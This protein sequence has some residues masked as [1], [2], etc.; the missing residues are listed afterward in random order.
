MKRIFA[1]AVAIFTV[2][3]VPTACGESSDEDASTAGT[4]AA[5]T[6]V[7]PDAAPLRSPVKTAPAAT[8]AGGPLDS[9]D[10][11][12]AD[13]AVGADSGSVKRTLGSP[14]SVVSRDNTFNPGG[15]LVTW[16]YQDLAIWF[17]DSAESFGFLL[18]GPA[19]ETRRGARVGDGIQRIRQLYGEPGDAYDQTWDYVD[20]ADPSGRR[21]VR[22]TFGDGRVV[23]IFVG[24]VLD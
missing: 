4:V 19:R 13:L 8:A 2:T 17:A 21:V 24:W 3:A 18:A 6:A 11:V 5:G 15:K 14:D 16:Y 12:V 9:A 10:F 1:L 22:F 23:E 7:Q 20:R